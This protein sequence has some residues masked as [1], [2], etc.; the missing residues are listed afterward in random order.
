MLRILLAATFGLAAFSYPARG[1]ERVPASIICGTTAELVGTANRL[2][3]VV[4]GAGTAGE[5]ARLLGELFTSP[6]GEWAF[7]LRSGDG[8]SCVVASGHNWRAIESPPAP[9]GNPS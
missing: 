2:G 8:T 7:M 5:G 4:S 1:A 6:D 3:A 9:V